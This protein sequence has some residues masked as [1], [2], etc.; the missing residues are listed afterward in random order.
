MLVGRR[1]S[2][3]ISTGGQSVVDICGVPC[4]NIHTINTVLNLVTRDTRRAKETADGRSRRTPDGNGYTSLA[5]ELLLAGHMVSF[6]L[7][8]RMVPR[9]VNAAKTVCG[10]VNVAGLTFWK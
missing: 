8:R 5:K 1:F 3:H 6:Q 4:E 9:L 2:T 10:E 7:N